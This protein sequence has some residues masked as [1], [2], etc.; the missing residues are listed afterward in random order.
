MTVNPAEP[1]LH[2]IPASLDFDTTNWDR[3]Q[4]ILLWA[5][6]DDVDNE[7]DELPPDGALDEVGVREAGV[8]DLAGDGVGERDVGADVQAEPTVGELGG[9]AAPR[10]H[11]TRHTHDL[12][13]AHLE[14]D[15]IGLR[16]PPRSFVGLSENRLAISANFTPARVG[17]PFSS[18]AALTGGPRRSICRSGCDPARPLIR[19]ASLRGVA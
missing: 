16:M 19:A 9:L 11:E 17:L 13:A 1:T 14:A 10:T 15:V 18:S 2:V 6:L 4:E 8:D 5:E 3:E 7:S 12:T